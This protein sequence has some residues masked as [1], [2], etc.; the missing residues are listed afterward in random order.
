M[1]KIYFQLTI[2]SMLIAA[3]TPNVVFGLYPSAVP[4]LMDQHDIA[5][6]GTTTSTA[7]GSNATLWSYTAVSGVETP[8]VVDGKVIFSA[9][10]KVF[11]LD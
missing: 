3:F 2:V 8:I 10:S 5:R 4:W 6:T 7:P 9:S 1:K 11:A